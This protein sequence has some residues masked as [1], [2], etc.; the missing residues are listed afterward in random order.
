MPLNNTYNPKGNDCPPEI[1][2]LI[3]YP[4]SFDIYCY[5]DSL[6]TFLYRAMMIGS[7]SPLLIIAGSEGRK[8]QSCFHFKSSPLS[9]F[10]LHRDVNRNRRLTAI[11]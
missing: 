7:I 4:I 3:P 11:V 10:E 9:C 6:S 2:C 1:R 8:N 5:K